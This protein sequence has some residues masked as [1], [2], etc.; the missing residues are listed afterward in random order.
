MLFRSRTG[1]IISG[2]LVGEGFD[3]R[4]LS[5]LFLATPIRFSG[6]VTQYL[7]RVLRPGRDQKKA[8]VFDY[9]DIKVDI[10]KA[11]ARQRQRVYKS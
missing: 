10:L 5:S 9:V 11:A 7:G 4:K 1:M 8:R 3:C 6:R 2:Q